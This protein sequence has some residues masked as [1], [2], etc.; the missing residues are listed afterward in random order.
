[1]AVTAAP[2]A[3][4]TLRSAHVSIVEAPQ[5]VCEV[6]MTLSVAGAGPVEHRIE[7]FDGSR[8]ELLG[9]SGARQI[10]SPR[11][12]GRTQALTLQPDGAEYRIGYRVRRGDQDAD[13]CALWLPTVPTDGQPGAVQIDV[14]TPPAARPGAT[15]P[16]FTWRGSHG[17]ATL[18]HLPAA[19]RVP[20]RTGSGGPAWSV[21]RTI[22]AVAILVFVAA[23]AVWVLRT[24]R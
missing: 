4:P 13:R 5:S 14:E 18:A 22:D 3:R 19:V 7:T 24:R 11:A 15:M 8:V 2:A 1:L 16:A 10:G 9:V 6:L 20:Y 23:S 21:A 17:S 12:I